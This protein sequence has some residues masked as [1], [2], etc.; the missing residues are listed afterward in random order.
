MLGG[1]VI[2]NR[3]AENSGITIIGGI[4]HGANLKNVAYD[5]IKLK[6]LD[7]ALIKGVVCKQVHITAS[8][9]IGNF[10]LISCTNSSIQNIEAHD[11]WKMGIKLGGGS[12]NT[13]IGDYFTGTH[14]SG[15]GAIN[16]ANIH[17]NGV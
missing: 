17:V 6:H 3:G 5:A 16:S 9:D 12:F 2:K 8:T 4:I 13:I 15:I 10:H 11:T 7:N 1:A 14:D